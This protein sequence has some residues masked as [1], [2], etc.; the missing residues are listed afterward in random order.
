[1]Q[2]IFNKTLFIFRRDLR[3]PD[4]I[5]FNDAIIRSKKVIPIFIFTQEQLINN[6]YKS[7]N[8][9]QFMMESL[10]SLDKDLKGLGSRL[11]YFLGDP[12]TIVK[13]I[14]K[15]EKIDAVFVNID[16]TPY[17]TQRDQKIKA[18]CHTNKT[19]FC[20]YEDI[21]I[22]PVKSIKTGSDNIY[23]KFTPYFNKAKGIKVNKPLYLDIK[24]LKNRLV[25]KSYIIKQPKEFSKSS[26]HRFYK[27]NPHTVPGGRQYALNI[28]NTKS[29]KNFTKYNDNR[30]TL[31][32]NTTRLSAYIKF[33]CVSIREVYHSF[34]QHLGTGNDLIK[35]LY[36]R[37]FYYNIAFENPRVFGTKNPSL[38]EKYNKI[39]WSNSKS[40]FAK[41]RNGETGFP[42]ID[43]CMRELNTIGFMHNR[44]RLIT[45][46]FLI[47]ILLINWKWGE[48][49]F[50]NQLVDYDPAVNNG[51]WQWSSGSG[52][53]SQPY[54]RIFNPWTQG[55][56]HDPN[57]EY[58]KKW[59]PE[60]KDVEPKHI[61]HWYQYNDSHKNINYP[62]PMIDYKKARETTLVEYKKA[63]K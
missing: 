9:I 15:Q 6:P 42:I 63:L 40:N 49:Y 22:N 5:G 54:F 59:V 12:S 10:E 50:A 11:F 3:I 38:K 53:D 43:A 61:H 35:Q 33:G 13:S 21:L 29:V 23:N 46:N 62:A 16:Y 2:Q 26:I 19:R 8:S 37:D 18:E 7:N 55:E 20:Y 31:K 44:G 51:N 48:K 17:S 57:A 24:L 52:A 28:L 30:N 36:W 34:L 60:L 32:I 41:W 14:C 56:K 25:N 58:I 47:K 1:M 27:K 4:N 45:S 39:K